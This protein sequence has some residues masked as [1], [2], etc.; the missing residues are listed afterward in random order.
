LVGITNAL[1]ILDVSD[2]LATGVA[3]IAALALFVIAILNGDAVIGSATLALVGSLI[4]FLHYNQPAARIYLGDTGSLF[5]GFMLAALAMIGAYTRRSEVAALAP[6]AVLIVPIL[7]TT[8]VVL[9]RLARGQSPFKGSPDHMALRL[10]ARG[11]SSQQI[12]W[13]SSGLG[14]LGGVVG[15]TATLV[16][17]LLASLLLGGM[18]IL[19]FVLLGWLW[20]MPA[21]RATS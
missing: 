17:P 14:L 4:G 8:L 1:N 9:A 13:L 5:V 12:L 20:R 2:G 7:D 10:K 18:G 6:L 11:L 19:F 16:E 15:V 3:A 21:P